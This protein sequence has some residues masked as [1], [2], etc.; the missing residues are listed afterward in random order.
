[1]KKRNLKCRSCLLSKKGN[2]VISLPAK[3]QIADITLKRHIKLIFRFIIIFCVA[4]AIDLYALMLNIHIGFSSSV[5]CYS[6]VSSPL[7]Q[8]LHFCSSLFKPHPPITST[9]SDLSTHTCLTLKTTNP[10]TVLDQSLR[11]KLAR[12]AYV[13]QTCAVVWC[14]NVMELNT[15]TTDRVFEEQSFLWERGVSVAADIF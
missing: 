7:S 10:E 6:T 11:A 13:M 9:P 15:G 4:T 1:M 5:Q 14:R 12:K 2:V 3:M 8:K